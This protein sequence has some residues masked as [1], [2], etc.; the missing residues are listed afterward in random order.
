MQDLSGQT[1]G[2]LEKMRRNNQVW[3]DRACKRE[4][5]S[6]HSG[7]VD[8]SGGLGARIS[9]DLPLIYSCCLVAFKN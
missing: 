3:T 4:S 7:A 2:K 6:S 8:R 1:A 5:G 9:F